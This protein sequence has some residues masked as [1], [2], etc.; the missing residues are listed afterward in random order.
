MI[1]GKKKPQVLYPHMIVSETC[2]SAGSETAELGRDLENYRTPF[3]SHH[4]AM[5]LVKVGKHV[6]A[7]QR[8]KFC[9]HV[10]GLASV[11]GVWKSPLIEEDLTP[12]IYEIDNKSKKND[13]GLSSE[14]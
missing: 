5:Q 9:S 6:S 2:G 11:P 1:V 12:K 7:G 3:P 10:V 4:A 14:C 13:F 8:V